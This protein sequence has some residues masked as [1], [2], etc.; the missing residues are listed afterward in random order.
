[1]DKSNIAIEFTKT[2]KEKPNSDELPFGKVFTDHMFVMD[3]SE[4]NG[5]HDARITPYELITLDPATVV[6]HYGQMVF[7]G[8]KAYKGKN[9]SIRLFRPE[10]NMERLNHSNDRLCIPR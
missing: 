6:F 7:E 5:W 9:G 10:K 3:Y 4:K 8:M 2:K 1:M